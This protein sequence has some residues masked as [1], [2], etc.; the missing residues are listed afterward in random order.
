MTNDEHNAKL[1]DLDTLLQE[2]DNFCVWFHDRFV[3]GKEIYT[4]RKQEIEAAFPGYL[5]VTVTINNST[6]HRLVPDT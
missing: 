2:D 5:V 4:S 3:P 1:H 6:T